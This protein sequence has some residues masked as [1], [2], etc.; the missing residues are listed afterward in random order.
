[1]DRE[2]LLELTAPGVEVGKF[3]SY[4]QIFGSEVHFG[5]ELIDRVTVP[6]FGNQSGSQPPMRRD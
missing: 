1:M 5:F 4:S 3:N 2:R 6:A